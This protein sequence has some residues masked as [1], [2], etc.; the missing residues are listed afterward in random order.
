MAEP[1]RILSE[2]TLSKIRKS[3]ENLTLDDSVNVTVKY[4]KFKESTTST[5]DPE[6]QAI[7][8]IYTDY[9]NLEA[10]KGNFSDRE[11]FLSGGKLELGDVRFLVFKE[12]LSGTP[13]NED[14]IV[15][16][17]VS[18]QVKSVWTDPLDIS[19]VFQTRRA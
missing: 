6:T 14:V 3:I 15:E 5:F 9:S 16:S 7:S 4:R 19:F 12:R 17:G 11:V 8:S 2:K 13:R 18:Y 1:R 10:L